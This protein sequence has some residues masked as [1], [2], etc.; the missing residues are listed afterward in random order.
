MVAE[1]ATRSTPV[2]FGPERG[3]DNEAVTK[4]S[5]DQ[6]VTTDCT[7]MHSTRANSDL[8][9]EDAPQQ[10]CRRGDLNHNPTVLRGVVDLST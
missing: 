5:C 8:T 3:L 2:R 6:N 10:A 4:P 1:P 7:L 9:W